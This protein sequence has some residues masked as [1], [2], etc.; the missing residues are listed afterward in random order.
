M[1]Y[2]IF[3]TRKSL[4]KKGILKTVGNGGGG[5][6]SYRLTSATV[7]S[8]VNHLNE[9]VV[10]NYFTSLPGRKRRKTTFSIEVSFLSSLKTR[11]CYCLGVDNF[12]SEDIR[13]KFS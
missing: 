1:V 9:K 6:R 10:I 4:K 2:I 3:L 13:G 11:R 12:F 5:V 8:L 7:L